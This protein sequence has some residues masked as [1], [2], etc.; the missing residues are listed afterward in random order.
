MIKRLHYAWVMVLSGLIL[1]AVVAGMALNCF[2]LFVIPVSEELGF[3]RAQMGVCQTI[4]ALGF[5]VTAI[6]SGWLFKKFQLMNIMRLSS[7]LI[8]IAYF[9]YSRATKLWMFYGLASVSSMSAS[10]LTWVPL[11]VILNNWFHKKRAFAIGFAFMGSGIGG[12]IFS[13]L[14]SRLIETIGWRSTFIVMA[15]VLFISCV[16]ITFLILRVHPKDKGVL[17]YGAD[18]MKNYEYSETENDGL[19]VKDA[20]QSIRFYCI[21]FFILI[22]GFATNGFTA[23]F[24]PHLEDSGYL[25]IRAGELYSVYMM[26]LA[27]GKVTTG[28]LF[29]RF[30]AKKTTL[31]SLFLLIITLSALCCARYPAAIAVCLIAS[32]IGNCYATVGLPVLARAV[33]GNREYA[34]FTGIFS[35]F[36]NIGSTLAPALMGVFSD[37]LGSYT[38]GYLLFVALLF[39]S[40]ALAVVSVPNAALEK[41]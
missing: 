34:S 23:T 20:V 25:S 15:A 28:S 39:V 26:V 11:S 9:L 40:F 22:S 24:V 27:F 36:G 2:S 35:T 16:P 12:M 30:G 32:G 21:L 31:L 33:Y 4:N 14:G 29:D 37:A 19:L 7:V 8:V 18:E 41:R 10:L 38:P 1:A 5:A 13:F 3:T 6:V 17:P